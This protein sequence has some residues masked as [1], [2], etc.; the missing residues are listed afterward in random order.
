MKVDELDADAQALI[1]AGR[2]GEP[3][4]AL[5]RARVQ[6]SVQTKLAAG[7]SVA[8]MTYAPSVL[9]AAGAKAGA[10]LVVVAAVATG[11]WYYA[12]TGTTQQVSA[13][14]QP[15][16]VVAP[17]EVPPKVVERAEPVEPEPE[18]AAESTPAET[19]EPSPRGRTEE[20]G[21]P[22]ARAGLTEEIALLSKASAALNRGQTTRAAELLSAYDRL[23]SKRLI[24][25]RSA[26]GVLL[27]CRSGQVARAR[28]AAGRF[29]KRFPRSPL[30]SRVQ[31]SCAGDS[32]RK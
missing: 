25:E 6:R 16:R 30:A 5:V 24:E 31:A 28:A 1:A 32:S 8:A 15:P 22:S 4:G 10:L 29:F 11:S 17:R 13:P 27:L 2:E 9:G 23:G 20:A 7:L 26:T 19:A 14:P 21:K 18:E 12:S 3:P